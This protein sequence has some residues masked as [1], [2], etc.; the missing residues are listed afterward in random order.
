MYD[1]T[2]VIII[3]CGLNRVDIYLAFTKMFDET[4]LPYARIANTN[5]LKE[6]GKS[7][8]QTSSLET[9]EQSES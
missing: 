4:C 1:N 9:L 8:I 3:T 7:H 2:R 6:T 5:H